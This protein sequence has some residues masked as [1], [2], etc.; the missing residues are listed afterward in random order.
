MLAGKG[1]AMVPVTSLWLP[2][3]V[4][5]ALVFVASSV[6]HMLLGYHNA[7]YGTV[8]AEDDVQSALRKFSLP[9]GD[10]MLPCA[11]STK[12]MQSQ[13]FLDKMNKGPVVV[14]TV[15]GNGPTSMGRNLALWFVYCVVV[16][17]FAGYVAGVVL[18]PGTHYLMIFRIAGTVA[19]ASYALG[20]WQQSIWYRR[21]WG[22]TIRS[23]VDGLIYA[24]L[25][26][27]TF[28]WLWPK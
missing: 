28:G 12:D 17:L 13:T 26:A 18:A 14:M 4:S 16:S 9:P 2:I 11:Q 27:G 10:Y 8:P 1:G 6:I 15:M 3:L 22:T 5:A 23:S 24:L 19:F 7:D 21:S 25:T 20:L